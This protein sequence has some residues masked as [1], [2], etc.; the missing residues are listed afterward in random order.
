[1]TG[2]LGFRAARLPRPAHSLHAAIGRVRCVDDR[3]RQA[4]DVA[5]NR[6]SILSG[7]LPYCVAG[8]L[9]WPPEWSYTGLAST[10]RN[11]MITERRWRTFWAKATPAASV[12]HCG[13][14]SKLP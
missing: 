13:H 3:R 7:R 4:K 12:A 9:D 6:L 8:R 10:F 1:V 11:R 2:K 14:L 5:A